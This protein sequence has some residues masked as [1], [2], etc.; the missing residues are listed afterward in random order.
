MT[1]MK[2]LLLASLLVSATAQ[3]SVCTK[4]T[5]GLDYDKY[6]GDSRCDRAGF[7]SFKGSLG[8]H[9]KYQSLKE[10]GNSLVPDQKTV[11][12]PI[13][14]VN[15]QESSQI[16][17]LDTVWIVEN[18][19][20]SPVVIAFTKDGVEYSA[21]NPKIT[22]PQADPS[23]ILQPR[24]W[25]AVNTYEGHTFHAR[26]LYADGS[27]GPVV[28][29]HRVGLI[30][31]G[32]GHNQLSCPTD[33]I[34][35]I[36]NG[37]RAPK[38][39]RGAPEVGRPCHTMD[40]GFRNHANCP[41]H[42]YYLRQGADD[43][44]QENFRFHLG[45]NAKPH[46]FM[47]SWDANTK[48]EGSFVGHAFSFRLA[49]NPSILVDTVTVAP[50]QIV[51]C[52]GLRQQEGVAVGADGVTEAVYHGETLNATMMVNATSAPYRMV[53]GASEL[54]ASTRLGSF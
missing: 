29:Q 7:N 12:C 21:R 41:L 32:Q 26:M 20:A 14:T 33:D 2:L 39:A 36:V 51:D 53:A 6:H 52:P 22:P 42:G 8:R 34:E 54:Y 38:Y 31:V 35:P 9:L 49:S 16:D 18:K 28:L 17:G 40:V 13:E 19:S 25:M 4:I 27:A 10:A 23:A 47:W 15:L 11:T 45:T 1:T 37:T 48:F 5:S 43:S 46:D 30:P 50:T 24:Q 3:Q 44:C